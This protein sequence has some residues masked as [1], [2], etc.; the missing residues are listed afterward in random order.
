MFGSLEEQ[1]EKMEAQ[2]RGIIVHGEAA[3]G[4]IK[5]TANGNKEVTDISIDK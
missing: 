2:L 5:I 3:G 1:Q 4:A